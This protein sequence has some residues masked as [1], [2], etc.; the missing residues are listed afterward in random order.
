MAGPDINDADDSE[1]E[2]RRRAAETFAER[3]AKAQREREEKQRKYAEARE[4]ILGSPAEDAQSRSSSKGAQHSRSRNSSR[5]KGKGKSDIEGI[6]SND[7]SPARGS[8]PKRQL[9]D[10]NYTSK[11]TSSFA[12]RGSDVRLESATESQHVRAPKG[13]DGNGH[14]GFGLALRENKA[15]AP[16]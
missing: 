10:P 13:P 5:G 3:Q 11:P 15:G 8:T 12:Q 16:T 7:Q 2:E 4:R 6:Q 14:G 1:E 9:F